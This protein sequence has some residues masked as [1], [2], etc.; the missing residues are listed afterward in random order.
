MFTMCM[1]SLTSY[2]YLH[3]MAMGGVSRFTNFAHHNHFPY[4]GLVCLCNGRSISSGDTAEQT[5]T[6]FK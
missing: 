6:Y 4:I 5:V 3:S 2:C 1:H